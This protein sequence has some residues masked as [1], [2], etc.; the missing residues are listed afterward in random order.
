MYSL[1]IKNVWKSYSL[2]NREKTTVLKD[3]S[4]QIE[5]GELVAAMG[6]SGSGK[7]TLLNLISGVDRPN[8]GSIWIEGRDLSE[9]DWDE[10]ALFRRRRLGMVFQDFNL[11][12]SLTV[13]ENILIP[14]ILEKK[15]AEEQE[16]RAEEILRIFAIEDKK[17]QNIADLSGGQKQR[18][19]IGRALVNHPAILL[20][21]EPTGNLDPKSTKE[22]IDCF[23]KINREF[24]T[25]ILMVTHDASVA[26]CCKRVVF[27]KDGAF[28]T[29]IKK[30]GSR[31]EFLHSIKE[32]LAGGESDDIS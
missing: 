11:I 5:P 29:E 2:R 15:S 14:M 6:P 23:L 30:T 26:S 27:L 12:E 3:L 25:S 4:L 17:D 22:A 10:L 7:T 32:T 21:D 28:L 18:T 16:E 24:G 13:R 31:T 8:S 9:L 1:E 19:A 20:A